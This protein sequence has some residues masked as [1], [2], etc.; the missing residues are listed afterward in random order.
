MLNSLTL[1]FPAVSLPQTLVDEALDDI[2]VGWWGSVSHWNMDEN[3]QDHCE[4]PARR[5]HS[6]VRSAD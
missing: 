3:R 4:L 1:D 2:S 6:R 5:E